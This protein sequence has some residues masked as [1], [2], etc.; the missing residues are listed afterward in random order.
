MTASSV[1]NSTVL[2]WMENLSTLVFSN[3]VVHVLPVLCQGSYFAH[4][5][6]SAMEITHQVFRSGHSETRCIHQEFDFHLWSALQ[7]PLRE[8]KSYVSL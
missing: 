4:L 7:V 6:S 5:T 2:L 1:P 8:A 3:M